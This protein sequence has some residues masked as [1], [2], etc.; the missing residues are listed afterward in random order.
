VD[1]STYR[2]EWR[3]ESVSFDKCADPPAASGVRLVDGMTVARGIHGKAGSGVYSLGWGGESTP[4]KME[5]LL[6]KYRDE[7]MVDKVWESRKCV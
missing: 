4:E 5:K 7:G 3:E 2:G 6:T 1:C